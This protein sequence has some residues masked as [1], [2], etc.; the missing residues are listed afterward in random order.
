M[1]RIAICGAGNRNRGDEGIGSESLKDIQNELSGDNFLFIDCGR[2][3]QDFTKDVLD[4]KP[5]KV[6]VIA[7][8]D[9]HR[10]SGIVESLSADEARDMLHEDGQVDL[11]M[12]LGYLQNALEGEVVFIGFQPW[13]RKDG[14]G[15][16]AEARN[17]LVIIR[18][19]VMEIVG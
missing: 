2:S 8:L 17:A 1:V 11:E 14:H 3:P 5:D 10:G 16:S 13:S 18:G 19:A 12:F 4:F 7:A 9:M 6:V 15:L